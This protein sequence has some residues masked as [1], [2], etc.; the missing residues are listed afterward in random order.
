MY[1]TRGRHKYLES[2]SSIAVVGERGSSSICSCKRHTRVYTAISMR[3]KQA[4][5]SQS[6]VGTKRKLYKVHI[7]IVVVVHVLRPVAYFLL[8]MSLPINSCTRAADIVYSS[9]VTDLHTASHA[10]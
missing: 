2:G 10:S 8:L 5:W 6:T 4:A 7:V 9:V 3:S 1:T